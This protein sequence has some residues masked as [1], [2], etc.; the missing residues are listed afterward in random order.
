MVN[1]FGRREKKRRV[2][3]RREE[4]KGTLPENLKRSK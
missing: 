1:S 2:L 4:T 3:R